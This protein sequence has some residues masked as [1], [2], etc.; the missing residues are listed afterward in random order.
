MS[1]SRPTHGS[2]SQRDHGRVRLLPPQPGS[3]ATQRTRPVSC[4][5]RTFDV[6]RTSTHKAVRVRTRAHRSL[7]QDR[8]YYSIH[9]TTVRRHARWINLPSG[10]FDAIHDIRHVMPLYRLCAGSALSGQRKC[11]SVEFECV[12]PIAGRTRIPPC[13]N[14]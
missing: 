14:Q 2:R 12:Q 3:L 9:R 8:R 1:P 10:S 5:G 13:I 6:R 11:G 7:R 4:R